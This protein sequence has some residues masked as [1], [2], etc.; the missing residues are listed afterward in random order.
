M[1]IFYLM[2]YITEIDKIQYCL[3]PYHEK[4]KNN[5]HFVF[6]ADFVL[7]KQI[8]VFDKHKQEECETVFENP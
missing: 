2:V 8:I 3:N 7:L 1:A 6:A 4:S 5:G